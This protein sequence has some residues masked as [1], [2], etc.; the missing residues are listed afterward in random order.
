[1]ALRRRTCGAWSLRFVGLV[2]VVG[3]VQI[4]ISVIVVVE[5]DASHAHACVEGACGAVHVCKPCSLVVAVEVVHGVYV[6]HVEVGEAIVVVIRRMQTSAHQSAVEVIRLGHV[7]K[8]AVSLVD[9]E[10]VWCRVASAEAVACGEVEVAVVVEV[11]PDRRI[12]EP[13]VRHTCLCRNVR[14]RHVSVVSI[15]AVRL[16]FGAHVDVFVS[17]AVAHGHAVVLPLGVKS[18]CSTH[19]DKRGGFL[20]PGRI[21]HHSCEPKPR[22]VDQK[23]C[24]APHDFERYNCCECGQL[25]FCCG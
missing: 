4:L 3:Q 19:V 22:H 10:S 23:V 20:A 2:G 21:H 12:C 25:G 16:K 6:D 18:C 11:N 9:V 13:F 5:E 14:E 17:I 15:K 7:H 24:L 8:G 1:M